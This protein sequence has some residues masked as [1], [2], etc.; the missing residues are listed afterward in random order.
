MH[1]SS[2]QVGS[3]EE[4]LMEVV[5]GTAGYIIFIMIHFS[6]NCDSSDMSFWNLKMKTKIF[7]YC[8]TYWAYS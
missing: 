2:V 4:R 7:K 5:T 6:D 1:E 3:F 8:F